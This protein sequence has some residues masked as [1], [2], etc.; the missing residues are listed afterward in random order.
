M[1]ASVVNGR[2]EWGVAS[3]PSPGEEFS[4]DLH[5]V[6]NK[7][8][9]IL[10][11]VVD[12]LGHGEEA[13]TAAKTAI[14]IIRKHSEESLISLMQRCHKALKMTRGTVMTVVSFDATDN[15]VTAMGVGNVEAVLV[16]ANP[17]AEPRQENVLLRA[18]V[19]G[20][21]LPSLYASVLPIYPG[22]V[23]IFTTDGIKDD[24]AK[25]LNYAESIPSMTERILKENFRGNDDALVL[26]VRYLKE[27]P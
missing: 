8:V 12:G 24:F 1:T 21:Q 16:R 14:D 25:R 4:G 18:G 5:L 20:Y 6:L 15:T 7:P 27:E 11:A 23:M 13:S 3:R 26:A 10:A 19:V 17:R 9:G 22:D 2:F